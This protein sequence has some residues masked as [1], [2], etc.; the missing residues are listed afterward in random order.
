[1]VGESGTELSNEIARSRI[2]L[3]YVLMRNILPSSVKPYQ[4]SKM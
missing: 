1:M 2:D 4:A 3:T